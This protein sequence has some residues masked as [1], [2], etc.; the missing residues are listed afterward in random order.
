MAT[1]YHRVY[2][3]AYRFTANRSDAEDLTQE[4]FYRAYRGFGSFAKNTN[5]ENWLLRI[6]SRLFLDMLPSL[7]RRSQIV[8]LSEECKLQGHSCDRTQ[9]VDT[10][11]SP[12]DRV[13]AGLMAD[14][15]R[16][17]I[18]TLKSDQQELVRQV[19]FE[20]VSYDELAKFRGISSGS[21]RVKLH[22]IRHRMRRVLEQSY[23]TT[24]PYS[25]RD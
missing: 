11:P 23:E 2:R 8:P 22:R 24:T 18:S 4:A 6:V 21:I 5:F 12:E 17:A 9:L 14:D 25:M 1:T 15:L 19:Y 7:R 3:A 13:F 10:T 16:L 20:F